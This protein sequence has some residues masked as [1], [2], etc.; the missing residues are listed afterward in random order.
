M[1]EKVVVTS[2]AFPLSASIWQQMGWR[3]QYSECDLVPATRLA[4][5]MKGAG[6]WCSGTWDHQQ[7]RRR[8]QFRLALR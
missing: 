4:E 7:C 3:L 8:R 1:Q 5:G 2:D 6:S